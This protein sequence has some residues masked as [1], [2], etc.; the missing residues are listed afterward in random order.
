MA[1]R[2]RE[3]TGKHALML[4]GGAFAVIIG[5]NIALAVNAVKTFP[6]LE[7]KNSY[8][9]SQEFDQRRSAQEALGWSVY[10]SSQ[11]DMVKLEITDAD[12]NPVEVAKLS[13]TLGR[14]THVQDD[15]QPEFAFDGQ[16]YVA[17]A[18]LGPGNWNI[19][20]VARAKNGTE[21]TQRVIL[22]VKG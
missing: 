9:A 6:G 16:A 5:V 1:K 7:V 20:M 15:Q 22:H 14:A 18:D 2:E 4:F 10:A 3:F 12:G 11:G 21:F 19:R 8:V 13:A 17:P